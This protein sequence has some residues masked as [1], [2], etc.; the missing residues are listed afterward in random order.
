L[1]HR[2]VTRSKLS[3]F[4]NFPWRDDLSCAGTFL[5]RPRLHAEALFRDLPSKIFKHFHEQDAL[6]HMIEHEQGRITLRRRRLPR[7][8]APTHRH[9]RH[10]RVRSRCIWRPAPRRARR[11]RQS[12]QPLQVRRYRRATAAAHCTV[13]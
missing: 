1:G 2:D 9:R 3:F 6:L 8:L 10:R 4:S 11:E 12:P 7:A 5:F 13:L